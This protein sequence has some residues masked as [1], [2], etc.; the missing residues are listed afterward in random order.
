MSVPKSQRGKSKLEV[1]E[2]AT[3]LIVYTL[4]ITSNKKV[5]DTHQAVVTNKIVD[6]ALS[7]GQD[8]WDANGIRVNDDVERFERR[9]RLQEDAI[10]ECDVLLYY[11]TIAKRVFHLSG[12]RVEYWGGLVREVKV[13]IRSW[14]DS[15]AKKYRHL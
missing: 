8:I 14:R 11:I 9:H 4:R 3:D 10:R 15:D 1:F 13:L 12:K 2:K 7:V 6:L 5:F